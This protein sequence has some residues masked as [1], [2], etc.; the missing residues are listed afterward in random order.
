MRCA[1]RGRISPVWA[2]LGGVALSAAVL[3]TQKALFAMPGFLLACL[4][5]ALPRFGV[6]ASLRGAAWVVVGAILP[7][8]PFLAFF[9]WHGALDDFI[10]LNFLANAAWPAIPLGLKG[11]YSWNTSS[12]IRC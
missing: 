1:R 2:A 4:C 5:M 3:T 11:W 6:P 10:R 7:W 8:L 12:R 9:A